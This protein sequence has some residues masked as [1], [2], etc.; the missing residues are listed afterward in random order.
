MPVSCEEEL[1]DLGMLQ[2]LFLV[3]QDREMWSRKGRSYWSHF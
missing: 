3:Q 1:K 2:I